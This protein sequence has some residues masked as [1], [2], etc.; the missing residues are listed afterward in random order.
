VN[1]RIVDHTSDINLVY[2]EHARQYLL[3][4]GLPPQRVIKTGSPM[5]EV[6]HRFASQTAASPVLAKLGLEPRRY[7]VASFHRE[8]NVGGPATLRSLVLTL[9]RLVDRHELLVIVSTH[10]RTRARLGALVEGP[11]P[12]EQVRFMKPLAFFDY[13]RLQQQS[14]CTL[15]DSGT[16]TDEASILGF[17]A[18]MVRQAHER[19]EGMDEAVAVISGL[20]PDRIMEAVTLAAGDMTAE[21]RLV[22]DYAPLDVSAKV[23]R[24]V[25]SYTDYVNRTVWQKHTPATLSGETG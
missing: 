21:R 23:V 1:R 13:V 20:D 17:P 11:T 10:P 4:E 5:R 3:R 22:P 2:T 7:I 16:L 14:F 25:L 12:G 19:P 15:S 24:I 6:L 9:N 18:V 8:E